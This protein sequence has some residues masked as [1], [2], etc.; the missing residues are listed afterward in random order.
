MSTHLII[1]K[2]WDI[3]SEY[4]GNIQIRQLHTAAEEYAR[5]PNNLHCQVFQDL[6]TLPVSIPSYTIHKYV[7]KELHKVTPVIDLCVCVIS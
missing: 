4:A 5:K 6:P 1:R 2:R 7:E 3:S